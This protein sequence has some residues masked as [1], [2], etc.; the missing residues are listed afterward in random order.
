LLHGAPIT[1]AAVPMCALST[2][3]ADGWSPPAHP[4]RRPGNPMTPSPS[5]S[6]PATTKYE[7]AGSRVR[8]NDPSGAAGADAA[9]APVAASIA[10][11]VVVVAGWWPVTAAYASTMP[12]P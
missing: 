4:K 10:R 11:T 12:V 5:S 3:I 2:V 9:T 1:T 6:C 8:A 7:P